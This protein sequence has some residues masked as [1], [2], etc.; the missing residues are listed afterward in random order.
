MALLPTNV[1][2]KV[3]IE[4]TIATIKSIALFMT[5]I[6]ADALHSPAC[7]RQP[8]WAWPPHHSYPTTHPTTTENPRGSNLHRPKDRLLIPHWWDC[9]I[10]NLF[11][12]P[13]CRPPC[14]DSI[15]VAAEESWPSCRCVAA[16][17]C[18]HVG[19]TAS[20]ARRHIYRRTWDLGHMHVTQRI[21]HVGWFLVGRSRRRSQYV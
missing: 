13:K 5:C 18:F 10:L 6:A 20:T 19:I 2:A 7:S 8:H 11:I 16:G 9:A 17:A 12:R 15:I 14:S 4:V 3:A 1:P 21:M